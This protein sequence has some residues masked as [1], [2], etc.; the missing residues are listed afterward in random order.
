[1]RKALSFF[2]VLFLLLSL[3][4]ARVI[5]KINV[6]HSHDGTKLTSIDIYNINPGTMSWLSI[7]MTGELTPELEYNIYVVAFRR[8]DPPLPLKYDDSKVRLNIVG[9]DEPV[10]PLNEISNRYDNIFAYQISLSDLYKM[11]KHSAGEFIVTGGNTKKVLSFTYNP[12]HVKKFM[13]AIL[14]DYL[15]VLHHK[16]SRVFPTSEDS[17]ETP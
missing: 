13:T 12:D 10:L 16:L 15:Y 7:S 6:T 9:L 4:S 14:P 11:T 1:M 17:P 3:S 5:G 2:I 8:G